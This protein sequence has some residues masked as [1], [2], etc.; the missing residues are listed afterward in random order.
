MGEGQMA[1]KNMNSMTIDVRGEGDTLPNT[2]L[3]Y[4]A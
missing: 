3:W 4:H 1:N 2:K